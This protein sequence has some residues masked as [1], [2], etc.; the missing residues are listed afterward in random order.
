MPE[1]SGQ[2]DSEA[3]EAQGDRAG[4]RAQAEEGPER[5]VPTHQLQLPELTRRPTRYDDVL[6]FKSV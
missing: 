5:Q 1:T 6:L 2:P 4:V 3:T